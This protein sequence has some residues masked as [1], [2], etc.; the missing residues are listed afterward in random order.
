MPFNHAMIMA[1]GRGTRM[2]PL[3]NDIPKAMAKYNDTTLI[4][5]GIAALKRQVKNIHVS[6]GY[7]KAMLAAHVIEEGVASVFCTE[8]KGPAWWIYN[9]LLSGLDEPIMVLT[10][11]NV[12]DINSLELLNDYKDK[13]CPACMLVPVKP[14]EGIE[15][16]FIFHCESR[17]TELSRVKKADKYCSGIQILNPKKIN[18]ITEATDDFYIVWSQLI[19]QGELYCSDIFPKKWYTAD[20]SD[21]LKNLNA[22]RL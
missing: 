14:I 13:N 16:D 19:S 8:G 6:V 18:R 9:T 3:T 2:I 10:C 21:Q 20:T 17:V 11:D 1:A 5:N 15:G 4:G 22:G 12:V 7:K